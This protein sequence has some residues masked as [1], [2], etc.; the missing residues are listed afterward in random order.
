MFHFKLISNEVKYFSSPEMVGDHRLNKVLL[1]LVNN[2]Y[3]KF[4]FLCESIYYMLIS[5]KNASPCVS[6]FHDV[7]VKSTGTQSGLL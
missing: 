5:G 6:T 7:T 1:N 3:H 2:T 4:T